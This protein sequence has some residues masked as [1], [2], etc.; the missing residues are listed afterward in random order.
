MSWLLAQ[1]STYPDLAGHP[2]PSPEPALPAGTD[3][4]TPPVTSTAPVAGAPQ[5]AEWTRIAAPDRIVSLTGVQLSAETGTAV[6][7]DTEFLVYGRNAKG[8]FTGDASI[9]R[10][11]GL[12]AAVILPATLPA[13]AE[14]WIWPINS[15]GAG[16]PLPINATEA[17]W[18][19]PNAATRGDTVSIYGRN[20]ARTISAPAASVYIQKAGAAGVWASVTAANPYKVDFTVP[21]NLGDGTYQVWIHNGRG[22]HYGWSGPLALTVNDGQPWSNHVFNVKNYGAMGDGVTDDEAAIQKAMQAAANSPWST[23]YLPTGTYMVSKGFVVPACVRWL[24]DGPSLTFLK[25]NAGF[26]QPAQADSRSYCL[27]FSNGTHDVVFDNLTIDA[28]GNLN[29]YLTK[30]VQ[31]RFTTDLRFIN[32]T[33]Q[34]KGYDIADFHGC[35]RLSFE[36]CDLIGGNGGIFFGT[37]SQVFVDHCRVYGT[38]DANTLLASWGGTGLSFTNSSG[39]DFDN[40]KTDGWA[41]GRFIYGASNWGSNRNIYIGNCATHQMAVRPGFYNQNSG[42]QLLWENCTH[43]S[44]TPVSSTGTTVTFPG[45]TDLLQTGVTNNSYDA[46]IVAGAGLGQHR[47]V[48]GCAGSTITVSP[49]WNVPPD[50]TSTVIL[51]ASVTR[52]VVYQTSLQ[53]KSDYAARDTASAG[54]QPFGN[55][56]DLIADTNTITQV[57]T[58]V[59]LWS[60]ESTW[61]GMPWVQGEYFNYIANN[62]VNHCLNGMVSISDATQGWPANVNYPG[63]SDFGNTFVGNSCDSIDTTALALFN[64]GALANDQVDLNMFAGNTVTNTPIGIYMGSDSNIINTG[65]YENNLSAGS[66]AGPNATGIYLPAGATPA[67]RDNVYNGYATDYSSTS[68]LTPVVEAPQHVVPVSATTSG[69]PVSSSLVL[70]NAG[71]TAASWTIS[72]DSPW[73]SARASGSIANEKSAAKIIVTCSPAG[74]K[75]GTYKGHVQVQGANQTHTYS[76]KFT[77]GASGKTTAL[78]GRG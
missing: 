33:I 25:A 55:G 72:S 27:F 9:L 56:Y 12:K 13:D 6:G 63:I 17:W 1:S 70:W 41:Q 3:P 54:F 71:A 2:V 5:G 26:V 66:A 68:T 38:N 73:L 61:E 24:G 74:L 67:L 30:P 8:S 76:V 64:I 31:L 53:G 77:V 69:A 37:A 14:Y 57:R 21:P 29:G 65:A 15:T 39:Q 11:N 18:L 42:E 4:F 49:A 35:L 34:A 75:A 7:S 60:M 58:A 52:C 10:L 78:A 16:K 59:A 19:G 50:A 62:N 46:V 32:T 40:T 43:Y 36:N 47:Q 23:V 20:L 28:N 45:G 22:G 51:A 44:C 48:I